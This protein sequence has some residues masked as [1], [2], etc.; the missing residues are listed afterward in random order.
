MKDMQMK[1]QYYYPGQ[2]PRNR[3]CFTRWD[4]W[5]AGQKVKN[6]SLWRY[7][8]VI[9]KS[10]RSCVWKMGDWNRFLVF[11]NSLSGS[12]HSQMEFFAEVELKERGI[13]GA[14]IQMAEKYHVEERCIIFSG[15]EDVI[16]EIQD[17]CKNHGKPDRLRLGANIRYLREEQKEMLERGDFYE[18]GLN[19]GAFESSDVEYLHQR[20]IRVFS[21]LGDTPVWWETLECLGVD[22]FKT[23]CLGAYRKWRQKWEQR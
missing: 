12:K 2:Q 15:I 5:K 6:S 3:M 4:G 23:N 21:N 17:W 7:T 14:V 20:G 16:W 1:N 11:R 8:D 22:G 13:A 9:K 18:V 19:A 10:M